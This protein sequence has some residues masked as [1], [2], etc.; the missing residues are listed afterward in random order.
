MQLIWQAE[1]HK[2]GDYG[3]GVICEHVCIFVP[4]CAFEGTQVL[5]HVCVFSSVVVNELLG[6]IQTC[7]HMQR[8]LSLRLDLFEYVIQSEY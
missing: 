2:I 3:V 5:T 6:V 7:T 1:G 4:M 8:K